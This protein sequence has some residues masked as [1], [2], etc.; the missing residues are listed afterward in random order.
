MSTSSDF[1]V[2]MMIGTVLRARRRL[3]TSSPSSTG[4][5]TSSTTR[6]KVASSKRFSAWAAVA[7]EHDLVAVLAQRIREQGLDRLLVVDEQY[8]RCAI[9]H[10][11]HQD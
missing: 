2:S 9:G 8:P 11:A 1:A 6:S 4:I 10:L 3:Q 7:R 5:I